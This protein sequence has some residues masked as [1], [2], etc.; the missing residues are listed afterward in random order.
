MKALFNNQLN[1]D[2]TE[3]LELVLDNLNL[4]MSIQIIEIGL[5]HAL[6]SGV[7]NLM[8]THSLYKSIQHLKT[9]EYTDNNLRDDDS[10]GNP[11]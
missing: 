1:F 8:E 10:N 7:F 5:E 4:K 9:Y 3:E 2:S 11:N 6:Y